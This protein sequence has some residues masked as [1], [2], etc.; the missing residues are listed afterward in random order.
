[1][2]NGKSRRDALLSISRSTWQGIHTSDNLTVRPANNYKRPGDIENKTIR[3]LALAEIQFL[4]S[5]HSDD[6]FR[7]SFF[8]PVD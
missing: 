3:V 4:V 6:T 7:Y 8:L 2:E 5:A 1:M